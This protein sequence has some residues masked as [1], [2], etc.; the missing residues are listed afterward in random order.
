MYIRKQLSRKKTGDRFVLSKEHQVDVIAYKDL[1]S[2]GNRF[3]SDIEKV[4]TLIAD[5]ANNDT[6]SDREKQPILMQ[7]N[8]VLESIQKKYSAEIETEQSEIEFSIQERIEEI[9]NATKERATDVYLEE[10]MTWE[11][12]AVDKEKLVS[13][14]KELYREYKKLTED[15]IADLRQLRREAEEQRSRIR[16]QRNKR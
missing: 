9:E 15:S 14:S 6:L 13:A 16:K 11:T 12:N 8:Q 7:L 3:D 2:K 4:T 1:V 5:I 10:T